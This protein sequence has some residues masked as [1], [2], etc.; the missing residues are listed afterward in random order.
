MFKI[1]TPAAKRQAERA[2]RRA[3]IASMIEA[4]MDQD[5]AFAKLYLE[6]AAD[7]TYADIDRNKRSSLWITKAALYISLPHQMGFFLGLAAALFGADAHFGNNP[8]EW[9]HPLSVLAGALG[10]PLLID[11]T[12]VYCV[13]N[14]T[15]KVASNGTRIANFAGMLLPATASCYIN[16]VA[17]APHPVLNYAFGGGVLFI[18]LVM[19][20][21][22]FFKVDFSQLLKLKKE[23]M[24]QVATPKAA[25]AKCPT[26]CT[27]GKHA[28]KARP[29]RKAATTRKPRT[30]KP[31]IQPA[32]QTTTGDPFAGLLDASQRIIDE[33][34]QVMEPAA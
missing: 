27:C 7:E 4:G 19:G 10:I 17:P 12:I 33:T 18:P 15:M 14:L 30:P 5:Q 25:T 16:F 13:R 8:M 3:R 11:N 31:A 34:R 26:G 6:D 22:A 21:R 24:A 20:L 29:T 28:P 9:V 2:D 23:T 1:Q 32:A